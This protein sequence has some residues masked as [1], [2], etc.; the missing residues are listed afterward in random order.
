MSVCVSVFVCIRVFVSVSVCVCVPDFPLSLFLKN[1]FGCCSFSL[2][3]SFLVMQFSCHESVCFVTDFPLFLFLI[4]Q[5]LSFLVVCM[6]VHV[7]VCECGCLSVSGAWYPVSG[8]SHL[9]EESVATI[10]S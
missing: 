5:F 6:C 10:L 3:F 7:C 1:L 8:F 9:G 2:F 4:F